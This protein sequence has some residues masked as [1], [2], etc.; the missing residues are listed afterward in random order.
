MK[1]E[2]K[3]QNIFKLKKKS[4]KCALSKINFFL[5]IYER[6]SIIRYTLCYFIISLK[7]LIE[8]SAVTGKM[9][10]LISE[11]ESSVKCSSCDDIESIVIIYIIDNLFNV[12]GNNFSQ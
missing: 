2:K 11:Y 5:N 10:F 12:K 6:S 9:Y 7:Y 3:P 8:E 1:A 4:R